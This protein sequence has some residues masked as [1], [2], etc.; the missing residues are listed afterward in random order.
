MQADSNSIGK[1]VIFSVVFILVCETW[2]LVFY[3]RHVKK[4]L[5]HPEDYIEV[6]TRA[7]GIKQYPV[8]H[9]IRAELYLIIVNLHPYSRLALEP[10]DV[11]VD[12][13]LTCTAQSRK[14]PRSS[15]VSVKLEGHL[16]DSQRL[17]FAQ[18]AQKQEDVT[19]NFTLHFRGAL[20]EGQKGF[21][22]PSVRVA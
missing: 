17:W 15:W 18:K 3:V 10:F 6:F 22:L 16:N 21:T 7:E 8:G 20:I 14:L 13:V 2:W 19:L 9:G 5:T 11:R 4:Y 1:W 12:D